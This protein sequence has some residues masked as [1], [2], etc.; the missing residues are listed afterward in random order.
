MPD[1]IRGI[2]HVI[3]DD[4][5]MRNSLSMLLASASLTARTYES[6]EDFL[7]AADDDGP[8]CILL[9]LRMPRMGGIELLQHLRAGGTQTP[10]VLISGH[11]DV[12]TTVRG[13]KLGAIDLL[14]KP[15]DPVV[16]I[17]SLH[18]ALRLSRQWRQQRE[19]QRS[20]QRRFSHLTAR[21]L[22]LLRLVVDGQSNKEIALELGIAVKTVTHHRANLM[23]KTGAINA[24]DLARLSTLAGMSAS[25]QNES[26]LS[27]AK[28]KIAA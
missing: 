1:D 26:K 27:N 19:E 5:G 12:S 10:V 14:Q 17:E 18:N 8:A 22:E 24:A 23:A 15:A 16:M 9:D 3:D 13:M 6:A 7:K 20:I 2:V 4:A 21:E 11:A 28:L 25:R